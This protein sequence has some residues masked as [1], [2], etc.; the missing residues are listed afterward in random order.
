MDFLRKL[1]RAWKRL[2]CDHRMELVLRSRRY[3]AIREVPVNLYYDYLVGVKCR[4]CGEQISIPQV[5]LPGNYY[6]GEPRYEAMK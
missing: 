6:S 2:F 4:N 3:Q 5:R 1:K